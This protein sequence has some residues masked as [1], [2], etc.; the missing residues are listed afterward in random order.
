MKNSYLSHHPILLSELNVTA[1]VL[2]ID[3]VTFLQVNN[4]QFGMAFAEP[5]RNI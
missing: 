2:P 5:I 1:L 4:I 3:S